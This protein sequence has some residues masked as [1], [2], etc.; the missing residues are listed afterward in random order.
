MFIK[1]NRTDPNTSH[2]SKLSSVAA[3]K[4][5][6]GLIGLLVLL[7]AL[8]VIFMLML[9][10]KPNH[11]MSVN[12]VE[13][14]T[15]AVVAQNET[16]LSLLESQS[17]KHVEQQNLLSPAQYRK[18]LARQNAPTKMYQSMPPKLSSVHNSKVLAGQGQFSHF[19]N[20]QSTV[21]SVVKGQRIRHP[22]QSIIEGEL[23]HAVLE[24]TINSEL[25]G[26]VRA[27]VSRPV[28]SYLG[29]NVLIP[30]GSRVI[31][32]YSDML[33]NGSA[34]ARLFIIWNRIITPQGISMMINSP[35]VDALGRAGQG[36]NAIEHHFMRIFGSAVL[37]SILGAGTANYGVSGYDQPNSANAYRQAIAQAFQQ[38][39]HTLLAQNRSI[40]P[41]L[42][43]YQG[44]KI[45]IFVAHDIDL[46]SAL[47]QT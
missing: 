8:A 18:R 7:M 32:Q 25:P 39:S 41:T 46:S 20:Q 38:S 19:A 35:G 1:K 27:V 28:Y 29:N 37:L 21:P 23:I 44:D 4:S 14:P 30:A 26:M 22:K 16:R 34:S 13:R 11:S 6:R 45:N 5:I 9:S 47:G 15:A 43:I 40:R 36:A 2:L 31:G 17:K 12:K 3:K 42:H 24:T 10:G 33:N